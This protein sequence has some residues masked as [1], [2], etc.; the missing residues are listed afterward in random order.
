MVSKRQMEEKIQKLSKRH[1]KLV[2][3]VPKT[4]LKVEEINKLNFLVLCKKNQLYL[5]PFPS[6]LP[7][8]L[9]P[10]K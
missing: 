7:N 6:W 3:R 5:K 8:F 1:M 9:N 10:R 4:R 2:K